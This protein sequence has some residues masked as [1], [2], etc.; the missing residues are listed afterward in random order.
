MDLSNY[1]QPVISYYRWLADGPSFANGDDSLVVSISNGTTS[2]PVEI[3][4]KDT[5]VSTGW[6]YHEFHVND[7]LPSTAGNETY[8]FHR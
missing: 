5:D 4:Q 7:Y 8:F 6:V 3:V 2:M 1:D